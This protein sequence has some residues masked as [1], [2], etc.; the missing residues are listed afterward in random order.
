MAARKPV[1][2]PF[3]LDSWQRGMAW[4]QLFSLLWAACAVVHA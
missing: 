3:R 2:L 4:W 1:R